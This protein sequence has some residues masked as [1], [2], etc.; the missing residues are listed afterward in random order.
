MKN[1]F[2]SCLFSV[3]LV[4][5]GGKVTGNFT[6]SN[7]GLPAIV[8]LGGTIA[9]EMTIPANRYGDAKMKLFEK[10]LILSFDWR[11]KKLRLQCK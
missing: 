11:V 10:K 4:S 1:L 2:L 3:F 9:K 5:C 6:V 7:E 8:K